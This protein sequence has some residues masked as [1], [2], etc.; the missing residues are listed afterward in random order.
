VEDIINQSL[1]QTEQGVQ[2]ALDPT[3]GHGL[4]NSIAEK[5]E[6]HPEVAGQPILLTSPMSRRHI[7]KLVNRFIPQL[8]VLSHGELN[9]DVSINTVGTVEDIHAG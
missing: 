7:F 3:Y 8:V 6:S 5:I 9:T 1:L 4:V 2:L